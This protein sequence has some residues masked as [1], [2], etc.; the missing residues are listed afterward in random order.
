MLFEQTLQ[1]YNITFHARYLFI[2]PGIRVTIETNNF[3]KYYICQLKIKQYLINIIF[4]LPVLRE[5][6]QLV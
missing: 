5:L 3:K 2:F 6:T 4:H 1:L